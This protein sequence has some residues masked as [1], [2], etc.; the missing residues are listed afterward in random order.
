MSTYLASD[1]GG[2]LDTV[3]EFGTGIYTHIKTEKAE[4]AAQV[5]GRQTEAETAETLRITTAAQG[6]TAAASTAKTQRFN[7]Q[8][9]RYA[10]IGAVVIVAF[11]A[12]SIL[13]RRKR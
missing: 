8:I 12:S 6:R 7:E 2:L 3:I 9:T 13:S 10:G 1:L 11:M 5:A 4:G